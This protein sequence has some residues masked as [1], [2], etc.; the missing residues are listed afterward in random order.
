MNSIGAF[1]FTTEVFAISKY[2][3]IMYLKQ[4]SMFVNCCIL[5]KLLIIIC[6][7][8]DFNFIPV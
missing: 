8:S 3:E 7:L 2:V 4:W 1:Q 6:V 5:R